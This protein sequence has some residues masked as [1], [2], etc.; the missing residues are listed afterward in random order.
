MP[1]RRTHKNPARR[2]YLHADLDQLRDIVAPVVLDAMRTASARLR[3]AGVR[4]ALVDGLAVGAYG[5][6]RATRD[7]DFLVGDECF[8]FHASGLVSIKTTVAVDELPVRVDFLS[9]LPNERQLERELSTGA[10]EN[11]NAVPVISIGALVY[12]KLK[13]GRQKDLA[14]VVE[15][16]KSGIDVREVANYL[17]E[18]APEFEIAMGT[19]VHEA[20][21]ESGRE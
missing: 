10:I 21:L 15:L 5:Y 11:P 16:L 8:D 6:V 20:E 12:L 1:L 7:V 2:E 19:L 18:F 9:V 14:D 4:H 3:Q 13:C 17:H